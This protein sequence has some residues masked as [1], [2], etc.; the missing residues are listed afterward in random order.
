MTHLSS[1]SWLEQTT[2]NSS[3]LLSL[4]NNATP[5]LAHILCT[6]ILRA[7]AQSSSVI[8][9]T[10]VIYKQ[11]TDF[12]EYFA[13][14]ATCR[15]M[16]QHVATCHYMSLHVASCRYMSL[17]V[18]AC[19]CLSLSIGVQSFQMTCVFSYYSYSIATIYLC[20]SLA[21]PSS[22]SCGCGA[23]CRIVIRRSLADLHCG[24]WAGG[25]LAA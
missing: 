21:P 18:A 24:F 25:W 11:F 7:T 5:A 16:S 15:Y 3:G 6:H 2:T 20:S 1:T 23:M 17:H 14:F 10:L 9:A 4:P 13:W 22:H 8:F 12:P 19:N